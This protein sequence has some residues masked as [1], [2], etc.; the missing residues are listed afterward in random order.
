MLSAKNGSEAPRALLNDHAAAL[1]LVQLYSDFSTVKLS[2]TILAH[3]AN[4]VDARGFA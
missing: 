4:A 3:Q 2:G 1:V